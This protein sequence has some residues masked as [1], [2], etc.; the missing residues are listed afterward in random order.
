MTTLKDKVEAKKQLLV[1]LY[2]FLCN[3]Y[4]KINIIQFLKPPRI[5]FEPRRKGKGKGGSAK[6]FKN[7]KIV[8]EQAKKVNSP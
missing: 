8:K 3:T 5:D 6:V 1:R 4:P 7:K 2:A